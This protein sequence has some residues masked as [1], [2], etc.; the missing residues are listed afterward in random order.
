M[1]KRLL[2][3]VLTICLVLTFVPWVALANS[4]EDSLPTGDLSWEND[5]WI[6][7]TPVTRSQLRG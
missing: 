4:N 5:V 3:I 2:S 7:G 6:G 1:K